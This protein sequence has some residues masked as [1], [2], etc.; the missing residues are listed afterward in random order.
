MLR[1]MGL[2]GVALA[3]A[4]FLSTAA[5]AGPFTPV[6]AERAP[7]TAIEEVQYRPALGGRCRTRVGTCPLNISGAK[8]I[9]SP[10]ACRFPNLKA[11]ASGFTVR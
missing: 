1:L 2:A 10:C 4:A 9:G 6:P 7:H 3:G 11:R 8:R 5:V